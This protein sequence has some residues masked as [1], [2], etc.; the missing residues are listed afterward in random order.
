MVLIQLIFLFA[1]FLNS[2][3]AYQLVPPNISVVTEVSVYFLF[4]YSF[5]SS[6]LRH[7]S[8]RFHLLP[9]IALFLFGSLYSIIL[10]RSFNFQPIFSLRLI[11]RFLFFYIALINFGLTTDKLKRINTLLFALF[12][13]QIPASAIK[14]YFYGLSESTMG[15]YEYKWRVDACNS[16]NRIRLFG[17]VLFLS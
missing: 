13:I 15:T 14:F 9:I 8:Y 6:S 2:L 1:F 12:I 3:V 4:L 11:L 16:N 10:N 17:W 5:V 7:A